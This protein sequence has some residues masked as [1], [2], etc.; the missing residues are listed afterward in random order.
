MA[1]QVEY[2]AEIY[3]RARAIGTPAV[4][5]EKEMDTIIAKF[6]DYGRR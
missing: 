1:E 4:L 5:P 6:A 2:C 3:W